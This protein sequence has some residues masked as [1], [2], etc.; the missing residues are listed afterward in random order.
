MPAMLTTGNGHRMRSAELIRSSLT[1]KLDDAIHWPWVRG[2]PLGVPV[3]PDVQQ[4][5][6]RMSAPRGGDATGGPGSVE[7]G[8]IAMAP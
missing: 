2:T 1:W 3:V 7:G 6:A 8:E 4:I 5:V